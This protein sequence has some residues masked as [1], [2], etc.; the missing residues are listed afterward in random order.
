MA[1][2]CFERR[3]VRQGGWWPWEQSYSLGR[4]FVCRIASPNAMA[5]TI[6]TLIERSLW[7]HRDEQPRIGGLM[8][9]V[10][11]PSGP[12]GRNI[13]TSPDR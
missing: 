5:A 2:A 11:H 7:P 3:G 13:R 1:L 6:A 4:A 12:R 10:R 9:G 8:H